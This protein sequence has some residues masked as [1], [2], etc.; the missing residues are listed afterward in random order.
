MESKLG[1]WFVNLSLL[2]TLN[3]YFLSKTDISTVF[4]NP[5]LS[6]SQI[7]S[8][9]GTVL[10]CVTFIL[11]SRFRFTEKYFGG[12]DKAYQLH[13]ML[14]GISFVLLLH[15]PLL[16]AFRLLPNTGAI[17]TYLFLGKDLAYNAGIIA[18]YLMLLLL[19]FTFLIN[20][21]YNVWLMTHQLLGISL[22]FATIHIFLIKSDVSR[23][24]PL[25]LW[26]LSWLSVA[27][28]AFIYKKFIYPR[29]GPRYEY[30]VDKISE[31]GDFYDIYLKPTSK[32][33]SFLP[34][35]FA[36]FTFINS[37]L[38]PESHPFSIASPNNQLNLR[39]CVK[40]LGDYTSM[41]SRLKVGDKTIVHGPYGS[42]GL[43]FFG[44]KDII[45]IAGGVGITPFLSLL[46]SPENY[47]TPRTANLIYCCKTTPTALDHHSLEH[48]GIPNFKYFPWFS[49]Q[50]KTRL[51]ASDIKQIIPNFDQCSYLLCGPTTMMLG[52]RDQLMGLGVP[53]RSINFEQFDMK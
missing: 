18:L 27:I 44:K 3:L 1:V 14:G 37:A 41:L 34:G 10:L 16:L 35:Q 9:I 11:S 31:N 40:K 50:S 29:F 5:F 20:L 23:Y 48:L 25:R 6:L 53:Q 46:N 12:L 15:H 49:D 43:N 7:V 47:N 21:P 4:S 51:T 19:I 36:F 45:A 26:M 39:I 32:T 24:L 42:F 33:M 38:A 22:I 2:I 52:L 28:I 17:G 30:L 8:L 13:H